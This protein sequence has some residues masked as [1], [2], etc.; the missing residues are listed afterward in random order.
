MRLAL[1]LSGLLACGAD[2]DDPA[3]GASSTGELAPPEI[4]YLPLTCGTHVRVG[5]G[6]NNPFS[7][8]DELRHAF[9]LLLALDTPVLAMAAGVV[10]HVNNQVRP[11][12]P[13]HDGGDEVCRPFANFVVLRHADGTSTLYKHLND[14]L[15]EVGAQLPRGALLGRSGTTGWSTTPHLHVMRMGPCA[16]AE[17]PSIP[18]AFADAPG[19]GVP[20]TGQDLTAM[21]CPDLPP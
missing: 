12:D 18:L 16:D 6:N 10:T 13:C 15:V 4:F 1:L 19:D 3:S 21:N 5:Q 11:G 9:D 17:C 2:D 14:A 20:I 7:H 8:H